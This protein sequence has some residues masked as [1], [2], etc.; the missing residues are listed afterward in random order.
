M[1]NFVFRNNEDQQKISR[2]RLFSSAF[3]SFLTG[4]N[5]ATVSFFFL[6]NEATFES[7]SNAQ[8]AVTNFFMDEFSF[9]FTF[10]AELNS[11]F[12]YEKS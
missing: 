6:F 9:F 4:F 12:A 2:D 7:D 1:E 8:A 5:A 11:D 3:T 10:T